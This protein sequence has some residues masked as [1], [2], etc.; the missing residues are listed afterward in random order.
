M[1]YLLTLITLLFIGCGDV[2]EGDK[3]T[4]TSAQTVTA[5]T[6]I[7]MVINKSYHVYSDDRIDNAS[8]DAELKVVTIVEN[9]EKEATLISGSAQLIRTN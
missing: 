7:D 5:P 3:S 4:S 2:Q 9:D 6:T 1:K 8:A